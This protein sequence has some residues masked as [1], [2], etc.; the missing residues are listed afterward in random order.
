MA[1][2]DMQ[3]TTVTVTMMSGAIGF[4]P[5]AV[6][7]TTTVGDLKNLFQ[8]GDPKQ[9]MFDGKLMQDS[10]TLEELPPQA[11]LTVAI[12]SEANLRAEAAAAA[13]A[14]VD[15][16]TILQE[17]RFNP[18]FSREYT[19]CLMALEA[20]YGRDPKVWREGL[21]FGVIPTLPNTTGLY[22]TSGQI[23]KFQS[24][25]WPEGR[26]FPAEPLVDAL[27]SLDHR[28]LERGINTNI[29][30]K[31]EFQSLRTVSKLRSTPLGHWLDVSVKPLLLK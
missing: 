25:C 16:D 12:V 14:Y 19:W 24:C 2:V 26:I 11:E 31:K 6:P 30:L 29:E 1:N 13:L 9:I 15:L 23:R 7:K 20:V 3:L 10:E 17:R 22:P 21:E 28:E 27:R 18:G 4:G 5:E 8:K